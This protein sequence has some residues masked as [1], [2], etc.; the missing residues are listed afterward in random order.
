MRAAGL[1][2]CASIAFVLRAVGPG[3]YTDQLPLTQEQLLAVIGATKQS[4]EGRLICELFKRF[5]RNPEGFHGTRGEMPG[6]R[7]DPFEVGS[8]VHGGSYRRFL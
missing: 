6:P 8:A 2:K 3:T 5:Q 1:I 4:H 7:V